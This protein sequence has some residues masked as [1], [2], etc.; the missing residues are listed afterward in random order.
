MCIRSPSDHQHYVFQQCKVST[1]VISQGPLSQGQASDAAACHIE[2]CLQVLTFS[3]E[4][5][6][7]IQ[8]A[9]IIQH[10]IERLV[11]IDDRAIAMQLIRAQT[12]VQVC[13]PSTSLCAVC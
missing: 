9:L 11:L 2:L 6:H 1:Y 7:V 5:G 10:S 8:N 4:V 13:L 12:G 3:A